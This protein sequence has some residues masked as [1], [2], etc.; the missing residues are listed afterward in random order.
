MSC[1]TIEIYI[2]ALADNELSVDKSLEIINHVDSCDL[3][4]AK[5]DLNEE[6]KSKLKHLS[7][8]Y[9]PP[10]ELVNKIYKEYGITSTS[11]RIQKYL[12]AACLV[13]FIGLGLINSSYFKKTTVSELHYNTKLQVANNDLDLVSNNIKLNINDKNLSNFKKNNFQVVGSSFIPK[14]FSKDLRLVSFKNDS[15]QKISLCMFPENFN[16]PTCHKMDING[17]TFYCGH[18]GN[19]NF[20]YWKENGKIIAILSET[21]SDMEMIDLVMPMVGQ[22]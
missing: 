6:I 20:T 18:E 16:M 21:L 5:W 9:D 8:S 14:A 10:K 4:K 15:G 19:C 11:K 22:V 13:G 1:K 7:N 12:I 17:T 3:C 2:S